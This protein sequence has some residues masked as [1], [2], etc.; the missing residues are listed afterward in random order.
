MSTNEEV[1]SLLEKIIGA[2]EDYYNE[3][4]YDLDHRNFEYEDIENVRERM[5]FAIAIMEVATRVKDA[6]DDV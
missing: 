2:A 1:K 6:I 3:M 5:N 4:D